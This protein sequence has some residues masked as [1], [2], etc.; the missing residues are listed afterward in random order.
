M[1]REIFSPVAVD[2]G[3]KFTG[4]FMAHG[5]DG[6][7]LLEPAAAVIVTPQDG[8]S[9]TWSQAAR[10]QRRHQQRCIK[11]RKLA[12]RLL[13]LLLT[14]VAGRPLSHDEVKAVSGLLNRRGYNR[15][16][17]EI[18]WELLEGISPDWHA[19]RFPDWFNNE[20]SLAEQFARMIQDIDLLKEIRKSNSIF[21]KPVKEL[22][23]DIR[24]FYGESDPETMEA[25]K[26]M[27][28]AIEGILTS[29]ETGARHRKEYLHNIKA[30]ICKDSRLKSLAEA[31]GGQE[32]LYAVIGHVSNLPLRVLRWY[33]DDERMK[34]GDFLDHRLFKCLK[35]WIERWRVYTDDERERRKRLLSFFESWEKQGWLRQEKPLSELIV[36]WI[37]KLDPVETIPP[38]EDMNNRRPPKDRTVW[39]DP[40][41]MTR[42][43]GQEWT[44][45]A[46]SLMAA[47]GNAPWKE[48]LSEAAGRLDRK[49]RLGVKA[50][51]RDYQR[52]LFLQRLLD[53]TMAFD[54]YRLRLLAKGH[55]GQQEEHAHNRLA[56]D[57]GRHRLEEFLRFCSLYYQE[58]ERVRSGAWSP[59]SALLL[60][61]SD[62]HPPRKQRILHRL[63]GQALGI[64][65]LREDEFKR[66]R[67]EVWTAR[68]GRTTVR[69]MC[70]KVEKTRKQ[71]GNL[72]DILLARAKAQKERGEKIDK[73]SEEYAALLAE[74]RASKAAGIIADHF[75]HGPDAKAYYN[76]PFTV[77]Q[78]YNLIERDRHGFSRVSLAA[79]LE[80]S[81]RMEKLELPDGGSAARC[82]RLSADT[83]RPFDG[84]LRRIVERQA[85]EVARIKAQQ[86]LKHLKGNEPIHIPIMVEENRFSFTLDLKDLK[87]KKSKREEARLLALI[88]R[89]EGQWLEKAERIKK[90]SKGVCPYTG[91]PLENSG[92]IDHILPRAFSQGRHGTVFNSEAN[93][94]W[95]SI[96][97]NRDK[98]PRRYHL[99][100]LSPAY[101]KAVFGTEN[102]EDISSQIEETLSRLSP[103]IPFDVRSDDEQ[104]ALRHAL[105]LRDSA[106][107]FQKAFSLL[108]TRMKNRVSGTQAWFARTLAW[109]I[110]KELKKLGGEP[111]ALR[112]SIHR[113]DAG[114]VSQLRHLL[115]EYDS[116]FEKTDSQGAVSHAV[117][118]MIVCAEACET[119]QELL[120]GLSESPERLAN[121]FPASVTIKWIERL[122]PYDP[123]KDVKSIPMF[124]D[125]LYA[126]RFLPI[127]WSDRG[128]WIGFSAKN[129]LPVKGS[130]PEILI[131]KLKRWLN[132]KVPSEP[133]KGQPVCFKINRKA[134]LELLHRAA[135]QGIEEE[136]EQEAAELLMTLRYVIV[137][138][139][140]SS[141]LLDKNKRL[142]EANTDKFKIKVQQ[143]VYPR[144]SRKP[145]LKIP[146]ASIRLPSERDW[147]RVYNEAKAKATDGNLT[148]SQWQE[149]VEQLFHPGSRRPHRKARQKY[150]LPMVAT[151]S[152][153]FRARRRGPRGELFQLMMIGDYSICG[154]PV[155]NGKIEWKKPVSM[156]F[157]RKS[158]NISP[159]SSLAPEPQYD[160]I[161]RLDHWSRLDVHDIEHIDEAWACPGT[162]DRMYVKIRQEMGDFLAMADIADRGFAEIP[163]EI[164]LS[165]DEKKDFGEYLD[166]IGKP[167]SNLFLLSI[168]DKVE[169]WFIVSSTSAELKT[170][171]GQAWRAEN[172]RG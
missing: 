132:G 103:D 66:F 123:K 28:V 9:I 140:I 144:R 92:E 128:V 164:K 141:G 57:L 97:G 117:D 79:H 64:A 129:W 119:A 158:P 6:E 7:N 87:N 138:E 150:S 102:V 2:L 152:G 156:P 153:A 104:K 61:R 16:E 136:A 82:T 53:R 161:I 83:V 50:H 159:A 107:A 168:G 25:H 81:W 108:A 38:Y 147:K 151:E 90:A 91:D 65:N 130:K 126:E 133:P 146:K 17:A 78:L 31:I 145:E 54:E 20:E 99:K 85:I 127:W 116:R 23:K 114:Q 73:K 32:Q 131:N 113:V 27:Q 163:A 88:A 49:S 33:F 120:P 135:K 14:E 162:K 95:V 5:S 72:F 171:Y 75:G 21:W 1:K 15:L 22:K 12:K 110:K 105:F 63:V 67:S 148:D 111:S 170:R 157:L 62:L 29:I 13:R 37:S 115:G 52:A 165:K 47:A 166:W 56:H 43:F 139:K 71:F 30:E 58:I 45:W 36:E 24:K 122:K 154:F 44:L 155:K 60:E 172:M 143:F 125:G 169:Y 59:K 124:K 86:I 3:A 96:K 142:K 68:H 42:E 84:I 51:D 106:P 69:A 89:Q 112:F 80:N 4:V 70:E 100:N 18:D 118:A 55:D 101:L 19:Q 11:R 137:K 34:Q 121:M 109:A 26:A 160:K 46:D 10:R 93:L 98:G 48:G 8:K 134:A 76:N 74:E 39:L 149:I 77:A 94:I 41:A 35:R 167:R 40:R